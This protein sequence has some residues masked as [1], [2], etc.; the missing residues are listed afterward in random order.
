[1][2][3]LQSTVEVCPDEFSHPVMP[4]PLARMRA[5]HALYRNDALA[6]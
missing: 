4:A 2:S 6:A 3:N 5:D 1:M